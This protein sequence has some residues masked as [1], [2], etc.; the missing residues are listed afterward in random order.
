MT[1]GLYEI[2]A[3]FNWGETKSYA[4][5]IRHYFLMGAA[6][7]VTS[8]ATLRTVKAQ[9]MPGELIFVE[10]A[11]FPPAEGCWLTIV[12]A[13]APDNMYREQ[14]YTAGQTSGVAKFRGLG[15]GAYEVRAFLAPPGSPDLAVAARCQ[16][17]VF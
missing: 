2:R 10:F 11:G 12:P 16:F 6:E 8:G 9:Y 14:V 1:P 7:P 4:V 3:Y 17:T 5:Q 15:A 13:A